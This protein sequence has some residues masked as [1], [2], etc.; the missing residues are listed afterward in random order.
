VKK[1]TEIRN[2][3]GETCSEKGIPQC[4]PTPLLSTIRKKFKKERE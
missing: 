2:V 4:A 1:W 3:G